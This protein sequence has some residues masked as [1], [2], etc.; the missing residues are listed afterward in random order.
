MAKV[1]A[2]ATQRFLLSFLMGKADAHVRSSC[3]FRMVPV[4]VKQIV[5]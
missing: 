4:D 3:S 1:S 2:F 5:H